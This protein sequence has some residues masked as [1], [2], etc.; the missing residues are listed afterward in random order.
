S[1]ALRALQH[2]VKLAQ[3]TGDCSIHLA[4]A[5]EEPWIYGEI[6][7]YS[8]RETVEKLQRERS[9]SVLA[10]GAQA[11]EASGIPHEKEALVGPVAPALVGRAHALGCDSIVM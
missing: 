3:R 9:E 6:A 11:L 8:Q 10:R 4:H 2:A 1:C 5:H 7:V